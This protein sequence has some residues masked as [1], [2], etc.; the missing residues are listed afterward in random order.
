MTKRGPVCAVRR[1]AAPR[2]RKVAD[3][4]RIGSALSAN[5]RPSLE[6]SGFS[7]GV[8]LRERLFLVERRSGDSSRCGPWYVVDPS[9][10]KGRGR[11]APTSETYLRAVPTGQRD[12]S[13][14]G[15]STPPSA[16]PW[17]SQTFRRRGE[18]CRHTL[19]DGPRSFVHPFA[20]EGISWSLARP[21]NVNR[22]SPHQPRQHPPGEG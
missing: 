15:S 18:T 9:R 3:V 22:S 2:F 5:A 17:C 14:S 19:K 13:F 16:P 4:E 21:G 20:P 6:G 7:T 12:Q 11:I 8:P 10:K 1:A